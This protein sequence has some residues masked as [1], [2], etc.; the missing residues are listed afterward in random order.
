MTIELEIAQAQ[1]KRYGKLA[2]HSNIVQKI[3][4]RFLVEVQTNPKLLENW[5]K[6][7]S[8]SNQKTHCL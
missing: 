7:K 4:T 6:R 2:K 3:F 5:Q 8:Q 1:P